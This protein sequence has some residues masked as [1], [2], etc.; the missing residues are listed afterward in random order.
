M[1]SDNR[2]HSVLLAVHEHFHLNTYCA[3]QATEQPE[4]G[5]VR[6]TVLFLE[7]MAQSSTS[8]SRKPELRALTEHLP[9]RQTL[10]FL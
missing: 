3:V 10:A 5:S 6:I 4:K 7:R 9:I 8:Q 1:R 2:K